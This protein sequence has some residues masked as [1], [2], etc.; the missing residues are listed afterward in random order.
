[1]L[2]IKCHQNIEGCEI[3]ASGTAM[4][5][6]RESTGVVAALATMIDTKYDEALG[7]LYRLLVSKILASDDLAK[8]STIYSINLN[9]IKKQ[10]NP[11]EGDEES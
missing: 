8:S 3:E 11:S 5:I 2:I 7:L 4:D 10:M 1:M 6:L 9:E